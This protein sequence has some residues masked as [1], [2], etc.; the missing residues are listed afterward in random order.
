MPFRNFGVQYNHHPQDTKSSLCGKTLKPEVPIN[1]IDSSIPTSQKA[2]SFSVRMTNEL[3][4]FREI[5]F[6]SEN[7]MKHINT[8]RGRLQKL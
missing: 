2:Y 8:L 4:V 1:N 5:I 3:M 7:R 6:Y